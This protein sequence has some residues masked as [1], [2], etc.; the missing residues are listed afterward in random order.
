MNNKSP[1]VILECG[2]SPP[3]SQSGS[4]L[5]LSRAKASLR[6][7]RAQWPHA[8]VHLLD[9]AGAYLV[10]AATYQKSPYF[11]AA[12]RLSF[13]HEQL[14][15]LAPQYGWQLQA[16]AV[17]SNHYHFVGISDDDAGPLCDLIRHLHSTTA[18]TVNRLDKTGGRKVW[19]QYWDTHLT[20]QSSYFSRLNYVHQN[21]VHHGLVLSPTDYPWCSARWFVES[22]DAAFVKTVASFKTDRI[23]VP[24]DFNLECGGPPPLSQSGSLLPLSKAKA[25]LRTP[26]ATPR[27]E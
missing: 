14:L 8:P 21:P 25:S 1:S 4:L 5:P 6:T 16:W 19:F 13:L 15:L 2:G 26:K 10:T 12:D 9:D 24:D 17:F 22:A 20:Y 3:L 11:A 23:K 7:P 18:R 27:N